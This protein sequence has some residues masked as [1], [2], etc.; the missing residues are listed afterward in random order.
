MAAELSGAI[1]LATDGNCLT[2][3]DYVKYLEDRVW[4]KKITPLTLEEIDV[5]YHGEK[6]EDEIAFENEVLQDILQSMILRAILTSRLR[7][8]AGVFCGF[9][10]CMLWGLCLVTEAGSQPRVYEVNR[11]PV[12]STDQ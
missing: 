2:G 4:G 1:R 3:Q 5:M 12:G 9:L 10:V 6:T 11:Y 7:L 8:E